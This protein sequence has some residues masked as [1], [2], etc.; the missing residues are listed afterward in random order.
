MSAATLDCETCGACCMNPPGNEAEGFRTW[1]E[2]KEG[3]PL[4]KRR[5]L[6]KKL[7]VVDADGDRHLRLDATGRC[8]ALAGAP[9]RKVSCKIYALRPH[10]CR[11]VQPGDRDCLS[12]RA[13]RGITS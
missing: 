3:E 11:R 10:P 7:V 4:L 6:V 9:G 2:V 12:Y 8:L 1:V 5:D 13:A